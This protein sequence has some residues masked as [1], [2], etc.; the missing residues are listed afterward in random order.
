MSFLP[1]PAQ[2]TSQAVA[3][4]KQD[5]GIL[6]EIVHGDDNAEVL[7]ENG[8]VPSVSNVLKDLLDRIGAGTGAD[9]T[10]RSDLAESDSAL[11]VGGT[12]VGLLQIP[13]N[14]IQGML[15]I[16]R[17]HN[18]Q[19]NVTSYLAGSASGGGTFV[20]NE[21]KPRTEHDGTLIID[22]TK[23]FPTDWN[24]PTE[25]YSWML[26][27]NTG[28]GCWVRLDTQSLDAS[29]RGYSYDQPTTYAEDIGRFVFG[30]EYLQHFISASREHLTNSVKIIHS[31]D[32]TTEGAYGTPDP[33][34]GGYTPATLMTWAAEHYGVRTVNI[35]AG[36]SGESVVKWNSTYV[37]ADI[38][39]NPNMNLYIVR[40]GIN[41]GSEHGNVSTF[42]A[43]LREGL[44]KLRAFKGV[45]NLSIILMSPSSTWDVPNNRYYLWYEKLTPILRQAARDFECMFF[46]TY[47]FLRDS[48]N[49]AGVWM[50][51]PF[52]DG[53]GIHMYA[54]AQASIY[55]EISRIIYTPTLLL[56]KNTNRFSNVLSSDL[57]LPFATDPISFPYGMHVYRAVSGWPHDGIVIVLKSA[58]NVIVQTNYSYTSSAA[59]YR[60]YNPL[61]S[62]WSSFISLGSLAETYEKPSASA[63]YTNPSSGGIRVVRQGV[64]INTDGYVE[65]TSPS[66]IAAGTQLATITNGALQPNNDSIYYLAQCWDG[67][68]FTESLL[69][70]IDQSGV[71]TTVKASTGT[72]ARVYINTSYIRR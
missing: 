6:H 3:L 16:P 20:Y 71:I 48:K 53:R 43:N 15:S 41:D 52:G 23:I 62:S 55:S 39:N 67:S 59:S 2:N 37:S 11:L 57:T 8:L 5:G 51:D 40:W 45:Q 10:V 60:S 14:S 21:T 61:T 49:G 70:K 31:G 64:V 35:N 34:L 7:T 4:I 47:A 13:V 68:N 46:D 18:R 17:I 19:C 27:S 28:T 58:D 38:T 22:P 56:R 50:D 30:Q 26:P 32:S 66:T 44:Q 12:P 42:E 72:V 9:L 1:F 65:K 69:L 54:E 24:N 36:H 29:S 33:V 63:G 25:R